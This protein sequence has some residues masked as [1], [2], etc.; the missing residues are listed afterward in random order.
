MLDV[1]FRKKKKTILNHILR[2]K[3]HILMLC[4][5]FNIWFYLFD[6][7]QIL[8]SLFHILINNKWHWINHTLLVIHIVLFVKILLKVHICP[9][10]RCIYASWVLR[11]VLTC[12]FD[13]MSDFGQWLYWFYLLN[14]VFRLPNN[15]VLYV[16]L[17][18]HI[19]MLFVHITQLTNV[20]NK[21]LRIVTVIL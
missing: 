15:H 8:L 17:F 14:H 4:F 10:A 7:Q 6:N 16:S 11:W 9:S 21:V 2:G 18:L 19:L 1:Y 20:F 5:F 13:L 12:Q 3:N